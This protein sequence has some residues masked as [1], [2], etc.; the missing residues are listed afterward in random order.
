MSHARADQPHRRDQGFCAR[1]TGELPVRG[2]G[3]RDRADR[4]RD[5]RGGWL[6]RIRVGLRP[7]PDGAQLVRVDLGALHRVA[8]GLDGHGDHVFV[9]SG[10]GLLLDGEPALAAR[11]DA[12][13]FLGG[14]AKS[15]HVRAIADDSHRLDGFE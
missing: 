5:Q 6:H 10:D 4:F 14:Q 9:E 3:V 13:N 15:G 12:R 7:D 2:L 11:P 8:C 1:L